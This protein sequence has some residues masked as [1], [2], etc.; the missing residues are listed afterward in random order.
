[1]TLAGNYSPLPFLSTTLSYTLANYKFDQIGLGLAI[2][3]KGAQFYFVTDHIPIRYVRDTGTGLIWP[4]NARLFNFRFGLNLI[5]DCDE[6]DRSGRPAG[7]RRSRSRS[8][9]ICPAYE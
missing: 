2:G 8:S 1:M 5:F 6:E 4:Y 9:K 3:G 7:L